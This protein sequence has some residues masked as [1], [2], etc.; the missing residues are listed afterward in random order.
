MGAA[1]AALT[2]QF[3][4]TRATAA[5][6]LP[7]MASLGISQRLG[8]RWTLLG[9]V[10]RTGWSSFDALNVAFANP[11]QAPVVTAEA[12]DDSWFVALGVDHAWSEQLALRAGIAFDQSPVGDDHRTPRV[13]DSDRPWL[14]VGASWKA[15]DGFALSV[16][17]SHIIPDDAAI[18]H[19]ASD[20]ESLFRGDLDARTS[21]SIDIVAIQASLRF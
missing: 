7:A 12:S 20:P 10:Q 16:G 15:A 21:A 11:N 4:D 17:Y 18:A 13:P 8:R 9:E 1:I 14:S 3:V 2:G 19:R 6:D 5:P